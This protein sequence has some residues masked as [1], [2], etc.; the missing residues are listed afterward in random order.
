MGGVSVV[1]GRDERSH[2]YCDATLLTPVCSSFSLHHPHFLCFTITGQQNALFFVSLHLPLAT[3]LSPDTRSDPHSLRLVEKGSQLLTLVPSLLSPRALLTLPRGNLEA[4]YPRALTLDAL[5]AALCVGEWARA[6]RTCRA[7]RVDFNLLYDIDRVEWVEE[8]AERMVRDVAGVDELNLFISSVVERDVREEDFPN[9]QPRRSERRDARERER[10]E[11]RRREQE[12]SGVSRTGGGGRMSAEADMEKVRQGLS[13]VGREKRGERLHLDRQAREQAAAAI[14]AQLSA[15][16]SSTAA[17]SAPSSLSTAEQLIASKSKVNLICDHLRAIFQRVDP[18]RYLLC[19]LTTYVKTAPPDLESALRL[20]KQLH[21][22]SLE[23]GGVQS[24]GDRGGKDKFSGAAGALA[25]VI[26]LC[27]VAQLYEVA[28]GMYDQQLA[29]LVAQQAQMDPKE[30]VP[31]LTELFDGGLGACMRRVGVDRWLKRWGKVVQ[32][33]VQAVETGEVAGAEVWDDVLQLVKE[34]TLWDDVLPLVAPKHGSEKGAAGTVQRARSGRQEER[35]RFGAPTFDFNSPIGRYHALLSAYAAHLLLQQLPAQA[36]SAYLLCGDYDNALRAYQL[37]LDWRLALSLAHSLN[38]SHTA[39]RELAQSF[40]AALRQQQGRAAE[41]AQLLLDYEEDVEEA[42]ALLLQAEEWEEAVRVCWGKARGDLVAEVVQP[43]LRKAVER[44]RRS[45]DRR[46]DK[47]AE[48]VRRLRIVRRAKLL[49]SAERTDAAVGG[50]ELAGHEEVDDDLQSIVS[51]SNNND[52]SSSASSVSGISAFTGLT[53]ASAS[54]SASLFSLPSSSGASPLTADQK[55]IQRHQQRLNRKA[56]KRRIKPGSHGEDAALVA[57]VQQARLSNRSLA[58]T[59]R[60]V[61]LLLQ[62]GWVDEARELQA[63]VEAAVAVQE[64]EEA[65]D[66]PLLDGMSEEQRAQLR[67]YWDWPSC[68]QREER[69]ERT[70]DEGSVK[71]IHFQQQQP[72]DGKERA[73]KLDGEEVKEEGERTGSG[74]HGGRSSRT[75]TDDDQLDEDN[76]AAF[77]LIDL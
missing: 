4:V 62:L 14:E 63:R 49:F 65:R 11:R 29:L 27:D 67:R 68:V 71:A 40:V 12:A 1:V 34:H 45:L 59:Q 51:G 69:K 38:F 18:Q 58:H 50:V 19:I 55:R 21:T 61:R 10:E 25:Y 72:A 5:T 41:A 57:L 32:G 9:L 46:R 20:V 42:V 73:D 36:A 47:Y 56:A 66:M 43:E 26:F 22:S 76:E 37:S 31:F 15:S 16:T 8:G 23:A 2:L 30:Y 75:V 7:N 13:N 64:A 39:C 33:L 53:T 54:S 60:T 17:S 48:A 24:L 35:E 28:V 44:T 70:E 6:Y 52:A 77:G 74:V 3:N